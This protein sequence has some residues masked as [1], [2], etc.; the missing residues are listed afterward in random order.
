VNVKAWWTFVAGESRWAPLGV[1]IA[2]LA[3]AALVHV[4]PESA[5]G[6]AGPVLIAILAAGLTASVFE[7]P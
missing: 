3:V 5:H 1:I 6:Y 7:R 4:A 2:L